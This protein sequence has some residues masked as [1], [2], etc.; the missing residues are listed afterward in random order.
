MRQIDN[1][2][3][4]KQCQWQKHCGGGGHPAWMA[5]RAPAPSR[6]QGKACL[7]TFAFAPVLSHLP[8]VFLCAM[9]MCAGE[10]SGRKTGRHTRTHTFGISTLCALQGGLLFLCG[11]AGRRLAR[12]SHLRRPCTALCPPLLQPVCEMRAAPCCSCVAVWAQLRG[13]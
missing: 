1:V 13:Q 5:E 12:R 10:G 11:R 7:F 4:L 3:S 9:P 2:C 8:Q 6:L